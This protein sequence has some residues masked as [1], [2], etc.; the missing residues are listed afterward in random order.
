MISKISCILCVATVLAVPLPSRDLVFKASCTASGYGYPVGNPTIAPTWNPQNSNGYDI[1]QGYNNAA[2]HTGIDLANGHVGGEVRAIASGVVVWRQDKTT[3]WGYMIRIR[4][5]LSSGYI[6]SQYGHMEA[7]S[8]IVNQG[9]TVCEGQV[10]GHVGSTGK[11]TG[12]HLHLEIKGIDN[13]GPGYIPGGNL[14]NYVDPLQFISAHSITLSIST[15]TCAQG[16]NCSG[17]QGTTFNFQGSGFTPSN[18]VQR[19]IQD[20]SGTQTELTPLLSADSSGDISWSFTSSC[21]TEVGPFTITAVDEASGIKS[22]LVTEVIQTGDCRPFVQITTDSPILN[23]S[24]PPV[25]SFD[26]SQVAFVKYDDNSGPAR[27]YVANS[28]GSNLTQILPPDLQAARGF[29]GIRFGGNKI[30]FVG[31][32][33]YPGYGGYCDGVDGDVYV[34][35]SD[36]TGLRQL[37]QGQYIRST[38]VISGDDSTIVFT[39]YVNYWQYGDQTYAV[40]SDG[41]GLHEIILPYYD[42]PPWPSLSYDGSKMAYLWYD[43][44]TFKIATVNTDGSNLNLVPKPA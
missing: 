17:P 35:N 43:R 37:S 19:F 39:S 6:Y 12:A 20:S 36:G 10:I 13:D 29:R 9:D 4:H 7:G 31:C 44:T 11:S 3:G 15:T 14:S 21:A 1:T 38:P 34:I 26:G 5:T 22:N 24:Q 30:A 42:G 8:L 33:L 27:L 28:D 18:P 2:G 25:I 16:T 23:G 40:N 41:S 32:P